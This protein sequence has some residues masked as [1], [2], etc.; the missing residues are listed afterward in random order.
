MCACFVVNL[1]RVAT[2]NLY[3]SQEWT[4]SHVLSYSRSQEDRS[5]KDNGKQP[6]SED[7]LMT[8]VRTHLN[9]ANVFNLTQ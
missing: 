6:D 2:D 5:D 4:V 9:K 1:K 3:V 8:D 7:T